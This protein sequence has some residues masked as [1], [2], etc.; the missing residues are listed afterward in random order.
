MAKPGMFGQGCAH[1]ASDAYQG[2]PTCM[3]QI[4]A[5]LQPH[6]I[7]HLHPFRAHQPLLSAL[8]VNHPFSLERAL[9]SAQAKHTLLASVPHS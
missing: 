4:I 8:Y 7:S 9:A 3:S 5:V 6:T 2:C 1:T